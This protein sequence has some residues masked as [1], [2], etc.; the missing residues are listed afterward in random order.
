MLE[1]LIL[2]VCFL[3][4]LVLLFTALI[5]IFFIVPFVPSKKRVINY[6]IDVAGLKKGQEVIDLG[7]GDGRFLIE[8]EKKAGVTAKGYEIAP[9]PLILAYLNKWVNNSKI[10][11]IIKSFFQADLKNADVIFCYLLPDT[12]NKLAEKFKKECRKGTRIYS[13]T[14]AIPSMQPVKTWPADKQKKLPSIYLY[15]I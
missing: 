8:A 7:C 6:I 15:Q 13:N 1:N 10:K 9:L 12:M 3:F 5:N 4:S 2:L 11:I 14:F